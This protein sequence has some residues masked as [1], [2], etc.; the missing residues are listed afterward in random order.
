MELELSRHLLHHFIQPVS[1]LVLPR[2]CMDAGQIVDG[3][4]KMHPD[5][6]L[7]SNRVISPHQIPID[8]IRVVDDLQFQLSSHFLDDGVASN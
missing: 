1:Q 6:S 8:L 3:L 7:R 5:E 4:M 2:D